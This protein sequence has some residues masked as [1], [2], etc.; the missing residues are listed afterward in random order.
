[1]KVDIDGSKLEAWCEILST[2]GLRAAIRRGVDRSAT[3]ARKVALKT[4]AQDIG[5]PVARIKPG[6]TK[7]RRTTQG[8]LSASFA[9]NKLRIGILNTSGAK[10]GTGGL[11]ASTHR[12]IWGRLSVT[13]NPER[14]PAASTASMR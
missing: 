13:S 1:M 12:L 7:L 11:T 10:V 3:A 2:R 14:M 5:A 9:A 6:V 8:D 4:I